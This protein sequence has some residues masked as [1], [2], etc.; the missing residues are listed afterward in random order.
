MGEEVAYS[1]AHCPHKESRITK[2]QVNV[3]PP[4][5]TKKAPIADPEELEFYELPD[6]EFRKVSIKNVNWHSIMGNSMEVPQ[7][8]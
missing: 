2:N 5:E 3:M 7:N 1:D 8:I 4:K 6:K